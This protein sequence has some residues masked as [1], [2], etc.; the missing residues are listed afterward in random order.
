MENAHCRKV[1][2]VLAYFNVDED[3][4]LSDDQVKRQTEKYGL[5]GTYIFTFSISFWKQ[6]ECLL[7]FMARICELEHC[8]KP[9]PKF[10]ECLLM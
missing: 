1:E 4:G 9:T 2:D 10:K 5:N 3:S 8:F 7:L 6:D